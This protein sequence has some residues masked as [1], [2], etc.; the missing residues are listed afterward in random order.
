MSHAL[1][2]LLVPIRVGVGIR[3]AWEDVRVAL[4]AG[5]TEH[6]GD[7]DGDPTPYLFLT[8]DGAVNLDD[9]EDAA[10]FTWFTDYP[11]AKRWEAALRKAIELSMYGMNFRGAAGHLSDAGYDA[12]W[13]AQEWFDAT[14]RQAL[15][16]ALRVEGAREIA[17]LYEMTAARDRDRKEIQRLAYLRYRKAVVYESLFGRHASPEDHEYSGIFGSS[18]SPS[19]ARSMDFRAHVDAWWSKKRTYRDAI[20]FADIHT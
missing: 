3:E 12:P 1:Y 8:D 5:R 13:R 4:R 15:V 18:V 17:A 19:C 20:V 10:E 6:W 11:V 2:L 7:N 9:P 14:P 16:E